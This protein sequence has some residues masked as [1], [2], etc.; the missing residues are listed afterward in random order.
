MYAT[1][2]TAKKYYGVSSD[3]LRRWAD[4]GKIKFIRTKG[5]H[6]RYLIPKSNEKSECSIKSTIPNAPEQCKFVYAR[7]SSNKQKSDLQHQIQ[8]LSNLFPNY[9]VI[10]DIGSGL[11]FRRKGLRTLLDKLFAG[12]LSEVVVASKDRL[13]RFGFDLIEDIFNK[14]NAR[15][16]VVNSEQRKQFENELA[17]DVLSVITYFTAK[18]SGKRKYT[19]RLKK[20]DTLNNEFIGREGEY[21][22]KSEEK[23]EE[24]SGGNNTNKSNND[25]RSDSTADSDEDTNSDTD[26]DTDSDQ[27]SDKV[28]DTDPDKEFEEKSNKN[29]EKD[30]DKV[31]EKDPD[32]VTIKK[33]KRTGKKSIETK[34]QSSKKFST[35]KGGSQIKIKH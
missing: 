23:S 6:R 8:F 29:S 20:Q 11:N 7:V 16:V 2:P 15:I 35:I 4:S 22:E 12:N 19:R 14:F 26:T 17:E 31:P 28:K 21:I 3:T 27:N 1:T 34:S 5:K 9:K 32:K 18:Y 10:A 24:M 30:I 13:A 33:Y 25:K